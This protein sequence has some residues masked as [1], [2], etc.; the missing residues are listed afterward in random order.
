MK[1][2]NLLPHRLKPIGWIILIP[3]LILG[4]MVLYFDFEIPGFT[5]E[6]PFYKGFLSD[7]PYVTNLTDELVSIIVLLSLIM[8]AFSEEKEED[9]WVSKVRLESLQWSV[10]AN[11]MLLIL[12]ILLVYDVYFF[13]ALV[14]NMYTILIF[15]ILR[16]NYVLRVKF[17]PNNIQVHEK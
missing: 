12:C 5:V 17:N 3:A 11:Y 2:S 13:Q 6:I 15:F 1:A 16:F 9:E 7:K 8:V 14:Y 4:V 10:Y